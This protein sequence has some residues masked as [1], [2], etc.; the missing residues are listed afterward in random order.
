MKHYAIEEKMLIYKKKTKSKQHTNSIGINFPVD[1]LSKNNNQ[2]FRYNNNIKSNNSIKYN[3]NNNNIYPNNKNNQL[4]N[5]INTNNYI[6]NNFNIN[7]SNITS[8]SKTNNINIS[9]NSNITYINKSITNNYNNKTNKSRI[10]N[11]ITTYIINTL[12]LSE[13]E[14]MRNGITN[15]KSQSTNQKNNYE[16]EI[17]INKLI[18][19]KEEKGNTI[20]SQKKLID[21]ILEDNQK[22]ENKIKEIIIEN[23]KIS[24]KIKIHKENQEQ[25]VM[26]VKIVQKSGVDVEELID[27]WNNK[28]ENENSSIKESDSN[29]IDDNESY[30]D[31]INELNSKIDPSS[32]IPINIEEP[33]INKKVFK[34]IPKLNFDILGNG[35]EKNKKQKFRNNS[36]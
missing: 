25:L 3:R 17:E 29:N 22:L 26:L 27:K 19:E 34:G 36:K 7:C 28:V 30:T 5:K 20:K 11:P 6:Q 9:P 21:R 33:H 4:K 32:F 1:L 23:Q 2:Y 14:F 31:S 12:N 15:T 16:Y 13:K 24:Q 10:S 8:N 35:Q 18:H